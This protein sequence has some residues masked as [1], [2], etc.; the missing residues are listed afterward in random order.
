MDRSIF[1]AV[2]GWNVVDLIG[3]VQHV[4][5]RFFTICCEQQQLFIE[6]VILIYIHGI[7]NIRIKGH[8]TLREAARNS[9]LYDRTHYWH[10]MMHG[11]IIYIN[12]KVISSV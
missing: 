3:F 12:G 5:K 2:I 1:I 9:P 6:G 10:K 7:D 4:R 11:R 8:M